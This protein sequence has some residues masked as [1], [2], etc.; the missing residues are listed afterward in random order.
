[1]VEASASNGNDS[2]IEMI[3]S[4]ER[5]SVGR[6]DTTEYGRHTVDGVVE[7]F[8]RFADPLQKVMGGRYLLL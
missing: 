4:T 1:M 5:K 8:E 3:S 6:R 7:S 2:N